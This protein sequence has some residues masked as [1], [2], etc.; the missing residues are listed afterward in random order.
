[1][2]C[3]DK[4]MTLQLNQ[5]KKTYQVTTVF[6][7]SNTISASTRREYPD[8]FDKSLA[9]DGAG[10]FTIFDLLSKRSNGKMKN[11]YPHG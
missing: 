10:R 5:Y 6:C 3:W 8:P 9:M 4:K 1:M 2:C 11:G 7:I